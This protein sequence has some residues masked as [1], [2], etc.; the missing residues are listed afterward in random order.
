MKN[1]NASN[2]LA[3]HRKFNVS[4]S[5]TS[6]YFSLFYYRFLWYFP[7]VGNQC[8]RINFYNSL[9]RK[10][11]KPSFLCDAIW[12]TFEFCLCHL[13]EVV[14]NFTLWCLHK[15][16]LVLLVVYLSMQVLLPS[17]LLSLS[18]LQFVFITS[19]R[20]WPY[21]SSVTSIRLC[22]KF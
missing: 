9:T 11:Y 7:Q 15:I 3:F 5:W 20:L 22:H 16:F 13:T 8:F 12:P 18:T 4:Y 10:K 19:L 1:L 17:I 21:H 6:N 14:I 2:F